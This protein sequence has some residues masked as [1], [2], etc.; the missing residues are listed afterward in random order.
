MPVSALS[1]SNEIVDSKAAATD[2]AIAYSS[3]NRYTYKAKALLTG[4]PALRPYHPIYLIGLADNMSG[5]WVVLEVTHVFNYKFPYS[6][7][8]TLGSNDSLLQIPIPT[9]LI[10]IEY[11]TDIDEEL[12][13]TSVNEVDT[14]IN[15]PY[16]KTDRFV[17]DLPPDMV[18]TELV[19]HQEP[20]PLKNT[21]TPLVNPTTIGKN[22]LNVWKS[23]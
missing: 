19:E 16:V 2:I 10:D 4:Y 23:V 7:Q 15:A 13:D 5:V 12:S 8:V 18:F 14:F 9:S 6:M 22:R 20:D 21:S 17:I 1:L 11:Q 3:K